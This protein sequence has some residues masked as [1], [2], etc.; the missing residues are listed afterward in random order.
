M[1]DTKITKIQNDNVGK[2][3]LNFIP[4]NL[5]I[6][7]CS[8]KDININRQSDGQLKKINIVFEPEN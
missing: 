1:K 3:L 2:Q 7:L 5:G 6:N 4:N 8:V